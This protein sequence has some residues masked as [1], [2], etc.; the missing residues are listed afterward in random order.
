MILK[1]LLAIK[2]R[3]LDLALLNGFQEDGY[4]SYNQGRVIN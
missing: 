4:D 1:I 3:R 2:G